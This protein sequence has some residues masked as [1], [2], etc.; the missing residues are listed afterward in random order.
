MTPQETLARYK[1]PS[2]HHLGT[3]QSHLEGTG[4][5]SQD[6][7]DIPEDSTDLSGNLDT[8]PIAPA[9]TSVPHLEIR[10]HQSAASHWVP[11][12]H[13]IVAVDPTKP[14]DTL[15]ELRIRLLELPEKGD[16]VMILLT[17][18]D[19]ITFVCHVMQSQLGDQFSIQGFINNP[20]ELYLIDE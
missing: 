6:I 14:A 15:I 1:S 2:S 7:Q 9:N 17:N 12:I 11:T 18:N 10:S 13:R 8:P 16:A 4:S 19:S 5:I 3:I 20:A